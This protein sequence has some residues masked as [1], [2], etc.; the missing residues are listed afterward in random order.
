MANGSSSKDEVAEE[1]SFILMEASCDLTKVASFHSYS[2]IDGSF[3]FEI[4]SNTDFVDLFGL[5]NFLLFL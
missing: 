1:A 5:K 2:F 4:K 3:S